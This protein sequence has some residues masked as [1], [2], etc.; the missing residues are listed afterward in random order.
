MIDGS[1]PPNSCTNR[2]WKM[3]WA[4]KVATY[5]I[6]AFFITVPACTVITGFDDVDVAQAESAAKVA[7]TKA[8]A[9]LAKQQTA[10]VERF[11]KEYNYS[12]MA[13]RC[14]VYGWTSGTERVTCEKA[15][16]EQARKQ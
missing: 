5:F 1:R 2:D 13:A 8:R 11:V 14:A 15:S 6:L 16:E 10:A 9:E 4:G 7:D 12:S 3:P